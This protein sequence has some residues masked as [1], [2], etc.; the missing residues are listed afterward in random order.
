MAVRVLVAAGANKESKTKGPNGRTPLHSAALNGHVEAIR[1]L[2]ELGADIDAQADN[3]ETPLQAS[4]RFNL[5]E[6]AQVL[7]ALQPPIRTKKKAVPKK[8]PPTQEAIDAAE[9]MA[10]LLEKEEEEEEER[11][12][13]AAAKCKVRSR[14]AVSP[15]LLSVVSPQDG[16][17]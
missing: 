7:K 8:E 14:P 2:V 11:E 5:H 13:A 9:R 15:P 16:W 3:G 1:A 12:K 6:A 17:W 4:V 10:A